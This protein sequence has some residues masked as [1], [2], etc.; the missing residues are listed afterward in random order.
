[1]SAKDLRSN[2]GQRKIYL[3]PI[4]KCL[5]VIAVIEKES[6][7]IK[8]KFQI[9][10]EGFLLQELRKLIEQKRLFDSLPTYLS[11]MDEENSEDDL[12]EFS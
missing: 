2:A 11:L 8:E 12:L 3:R 4:Q 6:N 1:M 7:A 9:C 5:S 10:N